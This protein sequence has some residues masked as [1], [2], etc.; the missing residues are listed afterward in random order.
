MKK[1]IT[2]DI[3]T[4]IGM[5]IK[6]GTLDHLQS[7]YQQAIDVMCKTTFALNG[8]GVYSTSTVYVIYG[9]NQTGGG[10]TKNLSAGAV[11]YNG[12]I[13]LVPASTYTI[14]G[15]NVAIANIVTSYFTG[16][17]A[18]PVTFT[19]ASIH[20][21]HEIKQIVVSAGASG[22]GLVNYSAFVFA[23]LY[24]TNL[25][26]AN[27]AVNVGTGSI[28][29]CYLNYKVINGMCFLSYDVRGTISTYTG[30]I[31]NLHL[32]LP[33]AANVG[34]DIADGDTKYFY[35]MGVAE[36]NTV[37]PFG[38]IHVFPDASTNPLSALSN[39]LNLQYKGST[40]NTFKFTGQIT[41][42]L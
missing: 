13:Y 19:D 3:T 29:S 9:C 35:N 23:N 22:S 26:T 37:T 4:G 17:N 30:G 16:T 40:A 15:G 38:I 12:E 41:Y 21:V 20:N 42:P 27:A 34:F 32:T 36:V 8:N 31:F 39:I 6:S 33:L 2:S 5:P 1:I 14:S 28:S 10:S 24:F 7:A 18:D 11:F 25:T